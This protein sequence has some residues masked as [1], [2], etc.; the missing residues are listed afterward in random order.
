MWYNSI[1]YPY[2]KWQ[3][4]SEALSN[5]IV[6]FKEGRIHL[7]ETGAQLETNFGKGWNY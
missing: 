3:E 5:N 1:E 7:K 6:F 2:R 4:F